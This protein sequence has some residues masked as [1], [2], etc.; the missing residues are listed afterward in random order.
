MGGE[1]LRGSQ[2]NIGITIQL[3]DKYLA[4]A[5]T[6]QGKHDATP[7]W[8]INTRMYYMAYWHAYRCHYLNALIELWI[9]D[10]KVQLDMRLR[11]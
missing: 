4:K 8:R 9:V 3:K 10:S 1:L 11:Y 6:A 7:W 5:L 2:D